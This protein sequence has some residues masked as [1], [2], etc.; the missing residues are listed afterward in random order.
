MY[1]YIYAEY[2]YIFIG[3]RRERHRRGDVL[4]PS[5]CPG[6]GCT[7]RTCPALTSSC[8][9]QEPLHGLATAEPT[10]GVFTYYSYGRTA[11]SS[12]NTDNE[13][14]DHCVRCLQQSSKIAAV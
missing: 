7:R 3:R 11:A 1:N 5:P 4:Q 14:N 8:G 6:L 10:A 9:S 13:G 12:P 2:T